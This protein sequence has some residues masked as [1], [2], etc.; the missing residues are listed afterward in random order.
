MSV[1]F[2]CAGCDLSIAPGDQVTSLARQK[3]E[4]MGGGDQRWVER[5]YAHPGHEGVK[6][7]RGY[8]IT[9]EGILQELEADRRRPKT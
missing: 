7:V 5:A 8:H 2:Q 1:V 6:L 4:H 3:A 9:G